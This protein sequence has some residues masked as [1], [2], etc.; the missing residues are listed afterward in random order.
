[1]AR[2]PDVLDFAR[3]LNRDFRKNPGLRTLAGIATL[4]GSEVASAG[5][6]LADDLL[7]DEH[8]KP[9]KRGA[10]KGPRA[11]HPHPTFRGAPR[12]LPGKRHLDRAAVA[13]HVAGLH[14][15]VLV[16]RNRGRFIHPPPGSVTHDRAMVARIRAGL[17]PRR[18]KLK[19]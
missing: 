12:P 18:S 8:G 1:M 5:F 19:E 13:R 6:D 14:G 2:K 16:D 4:G 15:P 11:E 9:R 10:H 17:P 7:R 3:K